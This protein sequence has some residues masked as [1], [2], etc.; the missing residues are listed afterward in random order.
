MLAVLQP[1]DQL[2][3]QTLIRPQP[4]CPF[5]RQRL[6]AAADAVV[7]GRQ[8]RPERTGTARASRVRIVEQGGT[9]AGAEVAR[10]VSPRAHAGGA[11]PG[12]DEVQQAAA[13]VPSQVVP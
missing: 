13:D 3:T 12:V 9:A 10:P 1:Q 2:T 8:V 6:A 5:E 11:D 4:E 7:A